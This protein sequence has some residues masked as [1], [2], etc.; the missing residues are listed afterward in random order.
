MVVMLTSPKCIFH[1]PLAF[2]LLRGWGGGLLSFMEFLCW[3]NSWNYPF[4]FLGLSADPFQP[5]A[6]RITLL[7][8][9]LISWI[10]LTCPWERVYFMHKYREDKAAPN[11]LNVGHSITILYEDGALITKYLTFISLYWSS[12]LKVILKGIYPFLS[13]YSSENPI[14]D[15]LKGL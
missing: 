7:G 2:I 6:F 9:L 1:G 3:L 13:T 12:S 14:G 8:D 4:G 5:K 11:Q 15:P 10:T